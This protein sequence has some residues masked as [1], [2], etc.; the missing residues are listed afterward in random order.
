MADDPKNRQLESKWTETWV[1]V[2]MSITALAT[3]WSA[4]Q[5]NIWNGTQTFKLTDAE[6]VQIQQSE[7]LLASNQHKMMDGFLAIS[8]ATALAENRQRTVDFL[9]PRL[10]NELRVAVE[11]WIATDPVHNSAAP[12]SPLLMPE[13]TEHVLAKFAEKQ[14]SLKQNYKR[15]MKEA[16]D[17]SQ[18]GD[19]YVLTTVLFATVLFF[20]GIASTVKTNR[21]ETF[22]LLIGTILLVATLAG[23]ATFPISID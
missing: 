1:A 6:D 4:Y 16:Q 23:L 14:A 13:Y 19:N 20:G 8:I 2:L 5:A 22:L 9:V 18:A 11:A 3:S 12:T 17:A 7:D 15:S 10:R 21:A